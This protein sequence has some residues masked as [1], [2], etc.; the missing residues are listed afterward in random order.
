MTAYDEI[1]QANADDK[2]RAW[3]RQLLDAIDEVVAFVDARL[4]GKGTGEYL[5]FLKGSFNLS[6]HIGFRGQRPDVLIRFAKPGHTN[7]LWRTE[8]VVNEVRVIQY[9]RQHTTIPLPCIR[10]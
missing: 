10:C 5:G 1:A 9:L 2:C 4:D 6:L 3:I 7:S 8:K